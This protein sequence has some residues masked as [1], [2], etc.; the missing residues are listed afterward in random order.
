LTTIEYGLQM[1]SE[2]ERRLGRYPSPVRAAIRDRL[3]EIATS[4]GK[5]RVQAK[6]P[7]R[8]QPP[9]CV[10]HFEGFQVL[11]QVDLSTRRVVVLDIGRAAKA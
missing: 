5:T 6:E 11:Y 7:A 8:K 1:S 2:L 4:A 9:L 3:R 10:Y